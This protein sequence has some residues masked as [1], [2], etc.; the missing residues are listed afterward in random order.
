MEFLKHYR[1]LVFVLLAMS[2]LGCGDDGTV[3]PPESA[4]EINLQTISGLPSDDVFDVFV[5]SQNRLWLSTEVGVAMFASTQGPF[6]V[7]NAT[8][9]TDREGLP[10]Q[11]CRGIAELNGKIYIG[12]WGGGMG[13]YDGTTPLD[14]LKPSDGLVNGRVFDVAADDTSIWVA[15]VGGVGQ[16]IDDES[17]LLEDRFVNWDSNYVVTPHKRLFTNMTYSSILVHNSPTR[18]AEI[19][20]T[21]RPGDSL[22]VIIPGGIKVLR[23]PTL[24]FQ[25]LNTETSAIPEDDVVDLVYDEF[26]E[27]FWSSF[28]TSGV[29]S[30][31]VDSK[32]WRN[33]TTADGI[34]SD[35]ASAVAVN[36][37]GAKWKAGTKWIATQ[38]G[39]TMIAPDGQIVNYLDGSGL[40]N[41][42][43]R[44]VY[45]DA[46]DDVWLAFV[47]RGAA[48]V[49]PPKK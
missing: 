14:A 49:V 47:E 33:L 29:A 44:K 23:L 21:Q 36:H 39:L 25:Y 12:T 3:T 31:E 34:V 5:D 45:V 30:L 2:A 7:K 46:N 42:R 9:F 15:T 17:R 35:L 11:K 48:K 38:E 6:D 37:T 20:A 1:Y 24:S 4:P 19:W 27:L 32:I 43:V 18:G 16:Y 40:P 26:N 22:G 13:V 41:V 10:N 28:P 8:V